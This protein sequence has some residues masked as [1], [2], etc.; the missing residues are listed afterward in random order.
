MFPPRVLSG[1]RC[2]Q[3][4]P[5]VYATLQVRG[6]F[7]IE[8]Q[9]TRLNPIASRSIERCPMHQHQ[10]RSIPSTQQHVLHTSNLF[11][12]NQATVISWA[13]V[14][15]QERSGTGLA[16]GGRKR[17]TEG[18]MCLGCKHNTKPHKAEGFLL[19]M[20]SERVFMAAYAHISG[21]IA[22]P[23]LRPR[24]GNHG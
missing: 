21:C 20:T 17:R 23:R 24:D 9:K 7:S 10:H 12:Q 16:G 3:H 4:N 19:S 18:A 6:Y 14:G 2:A 11:S 15:S 13:A 1:T 5:S 8:G 22:R